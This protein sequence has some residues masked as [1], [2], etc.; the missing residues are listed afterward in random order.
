MTIQVQ[1]CSPHDFRARKEIFDRHGHRLFCLPCATHGPL[2]GNF[3]PLFRLLRY[4]RAPNALRRRADDAGWLSDAPPADATRMSSCSVTCSRS[5]SPLPPTAR[6]ALPSNPPANIASLLITA[7]LARSAAREASRGKL[8]SYARLGSISSSCASPP[9]PRSR[10]AGRSARPS[11][12]CSP[13]PSRCSASS[14]STHITE[15]KPRFGIY[16]AA[17]A[18]QDYGLA[19]TRFRTAGW[20]ARGHRRLPG[21]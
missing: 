20:R 18:V 2:C 19:C 6:A 17:S 12:C 13:E 7:A 5:G 9:T 11:A 4:P 14:S 1:P 3:A 10:C 16:S 21:C 8:G 15:M